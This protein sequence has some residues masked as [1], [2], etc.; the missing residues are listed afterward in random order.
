MEAQRRQDQA[1]EALPTRVIEGITP[2]LTALEVSSTDHETRIRSVE[3]E[4]WMNRGGLA[5]TA[6]LIGW[7]VAA[8]KPLGVH[9]G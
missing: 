7:A 2:R 4:R 3:K 1:I 6:L 9:F 8:T 5:L